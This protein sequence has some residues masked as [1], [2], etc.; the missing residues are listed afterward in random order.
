MTNKV[1][2]YA[3]YSSDSQREE[4]IE[5][6][7]RAIKDY[8]MRN[9]MVIVGEYIDRAKSATS[10]RRPDFQRMIEDSAHGL[11]DAIIVHKLDRF[12]RD[13]Y[14]SAMYKHRLKINGVRLYSVTENL[15]GSPE[16]VILE[17]L[18][19][20]MA[21]YYSANLA[22][23]VMKGMMENA[24]KCLHTGGLPPL[25][26]DVDPSTKK[27]VI[28]EEEADTVRR[29]FDLYLSNFGYDRIMSNLNELDRKTKKGK[30]FG[31]N[32]LHDILVNEKYAGTYVFNRSASRD[33]RG[34]RNH[35]SS[36]ADII[37]IENGV[38][39]IV[40]REVFDQAQAKM[41]HN[42]RQPGA[43]RSEE[44]YLLSGLIYCGECATTHGREYAMA[45]NRHVGGRNRKLYVSYRCGNRD[46]TNI[47]CGNTELR[48]EY[49]EDYVIHELERRIFNE[50]NV[51][52]LTR[53]LNEHLAKTSAS[54][55]D[56]LKQAISELAKVQTQIENIV[57]AVASGSA[58]SS[59]LDK[60]GELEERRAQLESRAEELKA[61]KRDF[62]VTENAMRG[63]FGMF[64]NAVR[65]KDIPE[66]KRFIV[67]YVQRVVVYHSHVQV[68]F[69]VQ[70]PGADSGS[71]PLEIQCEASRGTLIK[72]SG[73]V[74]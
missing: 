60:M 10:D 35:H 45:G 37:R 66:I 73:V 9:E 64:R 7:T 12:S 49:I 46:R 61:A 20:G 21:Q 16:S 1:V 28:Q 36:K 3:R 29:I 48:R 8:A 65:D 38:P 15:D 55:K 31:K 4:S 2:I 30:P 51:P 22:R 57:N 41:A 69:R 56:E 43:Y 68:T 59:L 74:A 63:L 19:E 23:E 26:Y 39:A 18:L 27:L 25:G 50:A 54:G 34:K 17:S 72:G 14:D 67:S 32:S 40:T 47:P 62:V 13:R 6:Q 71:E 33:A 70:V 5:A 24:H 52:I 58:F 42:K 53:K 44:V 11:F